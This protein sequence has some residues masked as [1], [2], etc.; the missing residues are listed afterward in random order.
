MFLKKNHV[1]L[2][3]TSA[4]GSIRKSVNEASLGYTAVSYLTGKTLR[5]KK[6]C[7]MLI[8]SP[9]CVSTPSLPCLGPARKT[10]AFP[11]LQHHGN[12]VRNA[13]K[14]QVTKKLPALNTVS[15]RGLIL[16]FCALC[17]P[18]SSLLCLSCNSWSPCVPELDLAETQSA[19][20]RVQLP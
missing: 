20:T 19:R 13:L 3:A 10:A 4:V 16:P 1:I 14:T 15:W 6:A 2:P 11:Q 12:P 17:W 9:T 8:G 5:D 18:G 7:L